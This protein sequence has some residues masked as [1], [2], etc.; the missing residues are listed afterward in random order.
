MLQV[1]LAVPTVAAEAYT[2]QGQVCPQLVLGL[3]HPVVSEG[4]DPRRQQPGEQRENLP[5][6]VVHHE[7]ARTPGCEN[8]PVEHLA[9]QRRTSIRV[10]HLSQ[11]V[12]RAAPQHGVERLVAQQLRR[13]REGLVMVALRPTHQAL[14][15]DDLVR[16][17]VLPDDGASS[18]VVDVVRFE[19]ESA[20]LEA[21][22]DEQQHV[23]T[24]RVLVQEWLEIVPLPSDSPVFPGRRPSTTRTG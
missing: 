18:L 24:T 1:V 20:I 12:G 7:E 21:I 3:M 15:L 2:I 13:L 23:L 11:V 17:L 16:Y 8:D 10:S 22:S 4:A 19:G 6:R 14:G 5:T 9:V